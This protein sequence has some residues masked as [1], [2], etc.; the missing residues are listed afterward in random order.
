MRENKK[1]RNDAS[2][3][4]LRLSEHNLLLLP[5][6]SSDLDD[7]LSREVGLVAHS[8]ENGSRSVEES[9]RSVEFGD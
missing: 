1:E 3:I 6:S 8:S 4:E 5:S 2:C 7:V 9:E